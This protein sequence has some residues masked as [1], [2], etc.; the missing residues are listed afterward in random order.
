M[1]LISNQPKGI[2]E[3]RVMHWEKTWTSQASTNDY[4]D[5]GTYWDKV[6]FNIVTMQVNNTGATNSIYYKILGSLDGVTYNIDV[7]S[8][9]SVIAT[10]YNLINISSILGDTYIPYIKIQIK[11]VVA[12]SHSTVTAI[13][14]CM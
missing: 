11:S 6:G 2:N 4:V 7:V 14:V 10:D 12:G 1:S 13:G 8:E 5:L 9:T 3:V